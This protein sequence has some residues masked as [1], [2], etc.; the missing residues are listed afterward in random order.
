[1]NWIVLGEKNGKLLLVS[2]NSDREGMLP[3]GAFLT[4]EQ[5]ET[6]FILRVEDSQQHEPYSPL[7]LVID[8][9][10]TPLNQDRKCK[11]ILVAYR[12]KSISNRED[13]LIDY[14]RPQSIARLSNQEEIDL[15][16]GGIDSGPKVF[17]ATVQYD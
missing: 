11:N 9:D 10:L 16:L 15:A 12:V 6:K 7:P 13:I 8:M 5:G 3:K 1:M 4:I 2:K 14:I 17:V